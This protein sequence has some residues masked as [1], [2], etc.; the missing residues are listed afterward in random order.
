MDLELI[1]TSSQT[2]FTAGIR[3]LARYRLLLEPRILKANTKSLNDV[4]ELH[5][6]RLALIK[7]RT[8]AESRAKNLSNPLLKKHHADRFR[9][10]DCQMK[11]V[12]ETIMLLI[13]QDASLRARFDILFSVPACHRLLPSR[14]LSRCP[15][16]AN[17][18]RIPQAHF[19]VLRRSPASLDDRSDAQQLQAEAI[20]R[21]ALY[22]QALV[23]SR[24]KPELKP[25]YDQ[26]KATGKAPK[27]VITAMMRK[28]IVLASALL[29]NNRKWTPKPA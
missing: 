19:R 15:N 20:V 16:W 10:I 4:K 1:T 3:L 2:A 26:L 5:W 13:A 14:Y 8:A 7:D 23:A 9:Q 18:M 17:W 12:D 27:V 21:E 28:L 11:A 29:R 6:A 24:F 25:K 22:M